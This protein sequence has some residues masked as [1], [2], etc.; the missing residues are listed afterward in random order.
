MKNLNE[1][2]SLA[3]DEAWKKDDLEE[4]EA[5]KEN[6]FKNVVKI[7]VIGMKKNYCSSS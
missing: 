6:K 3:E 1:L 7:K 2:S 5:Q 4:L